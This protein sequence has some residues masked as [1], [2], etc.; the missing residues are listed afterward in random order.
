[1]YASVQEET[2]VDIIAAKKQKESGEDKGQE[3]DIEQLV[4]NKRR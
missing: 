3:P 4:E 1:M 2:K